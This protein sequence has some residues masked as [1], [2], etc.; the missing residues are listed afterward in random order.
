M[1]DSDGFSDLDRDVDALEA[2]LGGARDL[3]AAF[4]AELHSM[5][6]TLAAAD[7]E[8]K[9]LSRGISRNLR[10]S[11]ES[12]IFDGERLSD[13]MRSL[14][15]SITRSVYRSAVNP[16]FNQI[17][18]A[19]S[20][21]I[22]GAL[23]GVLPFANGA[24]FS[25]GRVVPFASGGIV[26]GPTYFPMRGATGLMGEAGPE[27]I[28]PLTR[29]ADGR[30]GVRAQGGGGPVNIVFNVTTPDVAGFERSQG[31]LAQQMTRALGR[32]SRNR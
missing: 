19:L 24:G 2:S 32:G 26:G 29:G 7:M 6:S 14:A 5:R 13:V 8:L 28:M 31:Q 23:S 22:E 3:A 9:G 15:E 20:S 27:A 12:L 11:F 25:Q 18:G 17:G 21:G 4:E 16:I 10:S 30:L 1:T